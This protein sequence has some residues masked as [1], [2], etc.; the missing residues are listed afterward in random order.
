MEFIQA[1]LVSHLMFLFCGFLVYFFLALKNIPL[2]GQRKRLFICSHT[3]G[4]LGCFQILAIIKKAVMPIHV[5]VSLWTQMFKSFGR[6]LRSM[7]TGLYAKYVQFYTKLTNCL[8]KWLYHV[9]VP[10]AMNER[11]LCSTTL[12]A[13]GG[14]S[15]LDFGH[16]IWCVV[17]SLCF[18]YLL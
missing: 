17:I 15:V 5:Q 1:S 16:S 8:L 6:I 13:F 2:S 18:I 10:S 14:I 12:S 3:E 4:P 7:I 11:S 9:V